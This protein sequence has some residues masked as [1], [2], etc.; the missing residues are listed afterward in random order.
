MCKVRLISFSGRC[1][2]GKDELANICKQYGY[3]KLS[4]ATP[5]KNLIIELTGLKDVEE[6]NGKKNEPLGAEFDEELYDKLSM[7]TDIPVDYCMKYA[8]SITKESTGRDWLQ[9]IGTDLIRRYD[10]DWHVKRTVSMIEP[11]KKY[12]FDDTRFPNEL[13]ALKKLGAECWF[14][15]RTKTDNISNHVSETALDYRMFEYHVI[16]NDKDLETFRKRWKY[17]LDNYE[18]A[19]PMREW[20]IGQLFL[21]SGAKFSDKTIEKFFVYE[22]FRQFSTPS[23]TPYRVEPTEDARG[24]LVDGSIEVTNPFIVEEYKKFYKTGVS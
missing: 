18:V 5:L 23:I 15:I 13:E 8:A 10:P 2:S 22:Y 3:T 9:I 12:V 11:D 19:K 6:L 20:L 1:F 14:I 7:L 4:F 24:F 21:N 16:V 17:Y